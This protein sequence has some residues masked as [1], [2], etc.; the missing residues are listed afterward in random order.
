MRP[1]TIKEILHLARSFR[2][3]RF[4]SISFLG[5]SVFSVNRN[6]LGGG[7][8]V[9]W[10]RFETGLGVIWRVSTGDKHPGRETAPWTRDNALDQ[11]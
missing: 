8:D 1:S 2:S 10:A 5:I 6:V 4:G 3:I 7:L 9:V 11:R